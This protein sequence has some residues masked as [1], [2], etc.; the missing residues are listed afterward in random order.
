MRGFPLQSY[1][2]LS[3][4]IT[5]YKQ[6][7]IMP[8]LALFRIE[9]PASLCN[10]FFSFVSVFLF[11]SLVSL[12]F[13]CTSLSSPYYTGQSHFRYLSAFVFTTLW[14]NH[15]SHL[16]SPL[17]AWSERRARSQVPAPLLYHVQR[18]NEAGPDRSQ[19]SL[20]CSWL[21]C[22]QLARSYRTRRSCPTAL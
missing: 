22:I 3:L 21:A 9:P 17:I 14:R 13:S 11:C 19:H 12:S 10:V 16:L 20:A 18:S 6:P 8:H 1:V 2:C 15:S 4:I 5:R 7:L